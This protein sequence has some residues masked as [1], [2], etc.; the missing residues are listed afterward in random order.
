[1]YMY[2]YI[3]IYIYIYIHTYRIYE[4]L[5]RGTP[6]LEADPGPREGI[7]EQFPDRRHRN[8]KAF[9]EHIQKHVSYCFLT[10]RYL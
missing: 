10:E 7:I 8:L 1:M 6:N 4:V 9:R 2:T 5:A 3:Y